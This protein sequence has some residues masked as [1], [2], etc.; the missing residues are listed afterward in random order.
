MSRLARWSFVALLSLLAAFTLGIAATA[1]RAEQ[2]VALVIGNAA[3]AAGAIKTAA[4]DAGL[5]AQTLESAGFEVMGARDL[6]QDAVRRAFRDFLDRAA[7][8]GSDDIALVYLGGYG[9]QLEGDNYFVPLDAR[10]ERASD[11]PVQ[12]IRLSDYTRALAALKLKLSIVVLDLARNHPFTLQGEPLAGGLAL[13][14]PD[15]GMLIAFNAAPGTLAPAAEGAYGP[16]A[17]ALAEMIREGGVQI[18]DLFDRVRLRVSDV[19]QGA[20]VPWHATNAVAPFVFFERTAEAPPLVGARDSTPALRSRAIRDLPPEEAY[21][22][23]LERDTLSDYLEF[24]DSYANSPLASRV[25]AIVAIRREQLIWRR[26][27]LLDTPEAYWA[28]LRLYSQ[29]PHAGDCYRRLAFLHASLEPPPDL[30]TIAYD[31]PPPPPDES[32]FVQQSAIFFGDPTYGFAPPP[33]ISE[34][35]PP[36]SPELLELPPPE[37]PQT[38]FLLPTPVYVPVPVWIRPPRHLQ[39][40][41]NV[42]FAN[43]HNRVVTNRAANSFMVTDH[44]GRTRTLPG[45]LASGDRTSQL[46]RP[47]AQRRQQPTFDGNVGP[48]LPPSVAESAAG[49]DGAANRIRRERPERPQRE[50][51]P[52]VPLPGSAV[53]GPS[54]AP[55]RS[56]AAPRQLPSFWD[57]R[58][59]RPLSGESRPQPLA[60]AARPTQPAQALPNVVSPPSAQ[61]G[62]NGRPQFDRQR[63]ERQPQQQP[64]QPAQQEQAAAA[65]RQQQQAA[66]GTA[67]AAQPHNR[68]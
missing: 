65:A 62:Q 20:Q 26:T 18:D 36:P 2:R 12:A 48:A 32:P 52:R 23:A 16:Y 22:G 51:L 41:D 17:Q 39:P 33:P 42:I 5:V 47:G 50:D 27:R 31:I 44:E 14:E 66:P 56:A 37:L 6:D 29:G 59:Q 60:P 4:N 38:A 13:V 49:R 67:A 3:Y 15:S 43:L 30:S 57:N 64:R 11:I 63:A 40:P 46:G 58:Q 61:A 24:L 68:P 35:L 19:T 53:P 25:R 54:G 45:P 1:A 9:L 21:I 7:S 10:M 55:G 34:F 28:Y 8:L